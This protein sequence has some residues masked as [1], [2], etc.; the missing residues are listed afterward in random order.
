MGEAT[1]KKP[2]QKNSKKR[3]KP[4]H[5]EC[6]EYSQTEKNKNRIVKNLQKFFINV[7]CSIC[8][9]VGSQTIHTDRDRKRKKTNLHREKRERQT[10]L[11]II[12]IK[13]LKHKKDILEKTK[14]KINCNLFPRNKKSKNNKFQKNQEIHSHGSGY[15]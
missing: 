3:S 15:F 11:R 6:Q 8:K 13:M 12:I 7:G 14:K 2:W 5:M 1:G 10:F 4:K 9:I